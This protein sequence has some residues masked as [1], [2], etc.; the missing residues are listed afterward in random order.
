MRTDST[1]GPGV[2]KRHALDGHFRVTLQR[3]HPTGR[4]AA[5]VPGQIERKRLNFRHRPHD[6]VDTS[7]I[8]TMG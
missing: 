6:S 3:R 4:K 5:D 1:R 2:S 7:F 8:V